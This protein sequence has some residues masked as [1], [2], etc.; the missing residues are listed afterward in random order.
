MKKRII[1]ASTSPRRKELLSKTGIPFEIIPGDYEEDM[2]LPMAPLEL[3]KHLSLGKAE[4]VAR[5]EQGVVIGSDTFI[6]LDDK[7]LGKPH[8]PERAREMLTMMRGREHRV[9]TGYAV[10][11]TETGKIISGV[12]DNTILFKNFS[13]EIMDAY[14]ATGEPL[15]R[16]GSYAIAEGGAQLV[17]KYEGDYEGIIGLPVRD[18]VRALQELGVEV[19]NG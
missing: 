4:S 6:V 18:V 16:A 7:V 19:S 9:V 14:I 1:L 11:D 17:E 15:D 12:S 8:T 13:D 5:K 10:I 2:T 3:A